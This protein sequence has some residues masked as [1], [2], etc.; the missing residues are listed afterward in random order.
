MI[1][2]VLLFLFLTLLPFEDENVTGHRH[3][4]VLGVDPRQL[5]RD[6]VR[7][8]VLAHVD[9]RR[10]K[11]EGAA[12]RRF[13]VEHP[14]QRRKTEPA[15]EAIEQPVHFTAEGLPYV[16]KGGWRRRRLLHFDRYL[17]H[18][19]LHQSVKSNGSSFATSIRRNIDPAQFSSPPS[20]I[21]ASA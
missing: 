17:C 6:L 3:V 21:A 18:R 4:D 7:P 11:G 1:V 12:P 9:R 8:L 2:L 19:R 16:G 20:P 5:G 13:D 15:A 14:P 10:R